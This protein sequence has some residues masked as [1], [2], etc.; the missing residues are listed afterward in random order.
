MELDTVFGASVLRARRRDCILRALEPRVAIL[1]HQPG[2]SLQQPYSTEHID[3]GVFL[4][5]RK[6]G[7]YLWLAMFLIAA[8]VLLGQASCTCSCPRVA[9]QKIRPRLENKLELYSNRDSI[10][11]REYRSNIRPPEVASMAAHQVADI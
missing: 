5:G 8:G 4:L 7:K 11:F 1:E 3:L 2:L 6:S 9:L 10:T